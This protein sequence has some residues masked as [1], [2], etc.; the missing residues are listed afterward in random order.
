M[1]ALL[2]EAALRSLALAVLVWWVVAVAR[3][4]SPHIEKAIWTTVLLGALAMPALMR[5]PVAR[6]I[7]LVSAPDISISGALNEARA[8]WIGTLALIYSGIFCVLLSR[9]AFAF[10]RMWQIRGRASRVREEWV[11]GGDVRFTAD[12]RSPVAFGST[13]LLPAHFATWSASKLAT[14]LA[15]E[16][17]HVRN[18]DCEVQWLAALHLCI[19]WFS[20]LSWWLRSHLVRLAEY[21]SD[22]AALREAPNRVEYAALL[23]EAAQWPPSARVAI[24]MAARAT[25]AQRID[26]ALEQ[27]DPRAVPAAWRSALAASLVLPVL[28]L[29]A[30]IASTTVEAIPPQ[31]QQEDASQSV[32]TPSSTRAYIV[33]A[34]SGVGKWYPPEAKRKGMPGAVRIAVTLD[35]AARVTDTRILSENPQG[36]G[37]GAAASGA[38]RS[39]IYANPTGRASTLI[40]NVQFQLGQTQHYGTTNF[41]GH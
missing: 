15:H 34:G 36:A 6:E 37:F 38:V 27:G 29:T 3:I 26:R 10:V 41:E 39:F 9:L 14:I 12:L 21:A 5:L 16:R 20:P 4:R 35:A 1:T 40:F 19:F 33:S 22:D 2:V 11:R 31:A 13:I 28:A 32:T 18:R 24:G 7:P 30:G 23:L 25:M 17:E 8:P